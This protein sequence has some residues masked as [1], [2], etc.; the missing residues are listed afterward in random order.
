MDFVYLVRQ[1]VQTESTIARIEDA[2]T[3]YRQLRQIFV[4]TGVRK[5]FNLPRQHATLDHYPQHI[6]NFGAPNGLCSSITEAKHIKA[7]K[8]PW[9]R[10][11]RFEALGQMLLTI[12]RLDKLAASRADFSAR[13]MLDFSCLAAAQVALDS[14]SSGHTGSSLVHDIDLNTDPLAGNNIEEEEES[15]MYDGPTVLASTSLSR[16]A[17]MWSFAS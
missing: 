3:R 13:G 1:S 8:E 17:G 6:R 4:R 11:S 5:D 9:R 2:I 7:V 14:A 15:G 10:S 12:Q 16:N